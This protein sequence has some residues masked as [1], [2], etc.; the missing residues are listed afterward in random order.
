M[1]ILKK[2]ASW[3]WNWDEPQAEIIK[4]SR[5][6]L[7]GEDRKRFIKRASGT[8]N[9]FLNE[10]NRISWKPGEVPVHLIALGSYEAYGPNLKGDAFRESVLQKYHPTFLKGRFYRYH[11][12]TNPKK[13]YG[14]VKASAYNPVMRRVE[15]LVGLNG[16]EEAA[17]RNG[18]LVADKEL[19]KLASGEPFPVS[20]S[21]W[22]AYDE[23]AICGNKARF[24]KEYCTPEKCP[25]G[26]CRDNLC[27]LVKVGSDIR[28]V[29]VFNH[30]PEFFDISMVIKPADRT[31][32]ADKA[33]YVVVKEASFEESLDESDRK[34]AVAI[35]QV[36]KQPPPVAFAPGLIGEVMDW[37]EIGDSMS[38]TAEFLAAAADMGAIIP[39]SEFGARVGCKAWSKEIRPF[40]LKEFEKLASGESPLSPLGSAVKRAIPS[41]ALFKKAA[42]RAQKFSLDKN[43]ILQRARQKIWYDGIRF[44]D[45]VVKSSSC[46]PASEE[47]ARQYASYVVAALPRALKTSSDIE[48][49]VRCAYWQNLV[50]AGA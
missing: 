14:I 15:L 3:S 20:M 46:D 19:T 42:A 47:L 2:I 18:G 4:I 45:R 38:K 16:N 36:A 41:Q 49:T 44:S 26:G 40:L 27:K 34:V 7:I 50:D 21:C 35:C 9:I 6:G 29:F 1:A 48:L 22:V 5:Y 8:E 43:A 24:R 13:S 32:W 39:F 28:H 37:S 23:C 17:R 10:L 25:G 30:Q 33:N 31:A 12:N 11:E